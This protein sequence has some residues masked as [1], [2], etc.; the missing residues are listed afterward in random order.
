MELS[1]PVTVTLTLREYRRIVIV[2]YLAD[3][4]GEITIPESTFREVILP[5]AVTCYKI[6]C[7]DMARHPCLISERNS[8]RVFV[9][10][11]DFDDF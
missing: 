3:C 1:R 5:R 7:S 6:I 9:G 8:V 4:C 2:A 11:H 10:S